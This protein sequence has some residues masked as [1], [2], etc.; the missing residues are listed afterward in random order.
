MSVR[1]EPLTGEVYPP[2]KSPRQVRWLESEPDSPH[3]KL[4]RIIATS[5]SADEHAL[6]EKIL[7]RAATLGADA[8][9]MGKS[10]V[11]ESVGTGTAPQSTMGPA[12][13]SFGGG[14]LSIMTVGVS[15]KV[16]WMRRD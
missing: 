15:R 10:D 9:V 1:V 13:G 3:I 11:L 7:A 5:Q 14:G 6:R 2:H 12:G 4:A 8:V 16:Q